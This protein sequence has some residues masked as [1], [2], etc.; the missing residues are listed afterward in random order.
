M[1]HQVK[2]KNRGIRESIIEIAFIPVTPEEK[3]LIDGAKKAELNE[4]DFEKWNDLLT[5]ICLNNNFSPI[6]CDCYA[7]RWI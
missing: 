6:G 5:S 1:K 2:T 4:E 3:I 7:G